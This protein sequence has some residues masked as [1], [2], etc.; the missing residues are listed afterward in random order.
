[1]TPSF[2]PVDARDFHAT[3]QAS[4]RRAGRF[5]AAGTLPPLA[6]EV[7]GVGAYTYSLADDRIAITH[8]VG[9]APVHVKLDT[10]AFT[11]F[12][13]ELLTVTGLQITRKV[14]YQA[15][16][17]FGFAA[18]EPV[19][20]WLYSGRPLYDPADFADLEPSGGFDWS[21]SD[22]ELTGNLARHGYLVL[23]GVYTPAEVDLLAAEV[24]RIRAGATTADRQSWWTTRPDGSDA[25][26]QL[27]YTNLQSD[28]IAALDADPRIERIARLVVEPVV[29]G[30]TCG[31]GTFAVLKNP[32]ASSGLTNLPW[33]IDCGLGGH[34]VL[35]PGVNIGIQ[36][37]AA[38]FET[39]AMRFLAGSHNRT[40][41]TRLGEPAGP[42]A[43]VEAQPGDVT[44]HL[45]HM[46][47]EAPP[48]T[49]DAGRRTLYV[50]MVP[51]G[52]PEYL[53]YRN[54]YD[55]ML[56]DAD[57]DGHVSFDAG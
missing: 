23:R 29:S 41:V 46:L 45:G 30:S 36:L 26:C 49:G 44:V 15:G 52:T 16:D 22:D 50:S 24:E 48:P 14:N 9:S 37:T 2:A 35:C 33:H 56:F 20:R 39:G 51:P 28:A 43:L 13:H 40:V 18:W 47:H 54:G 6:I 53:G 17:Y 32:L 34:P 21:A 27:L 12:A 5:A 7:D 3:L 57:G 55:H 1:M 4:P 10:G 31:N 8:E 25:V 11:Q 19:L 42:V 38:N